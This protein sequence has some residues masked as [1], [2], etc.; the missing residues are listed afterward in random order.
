MQNKEKLR[1]KFKKIRKKNYFEVNNNFFKPVFSF[2]KNSK[3][4]LIKISLYYPTNYEVNTLKFFELNNFKKNVITLLP[5]IAS[6]EIMKFYRWNYLDVLKVNKYG[7]LEPSVKKKIIIPDLI[8]VPLL[9]FD[10]KNNRLGYGKGYYD[11]FL[12]KY[13]RLNKH[14]ITIG[15]AFSFQKYNKLPISKHDVKLNYIITEKGLLRG[16]KY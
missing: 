4:K 2:L 9:S 14:I 6:G 16:W 7:I 5:S 3:K 1:I 10:S 13:L 12:N 8:L 15:V 11:K